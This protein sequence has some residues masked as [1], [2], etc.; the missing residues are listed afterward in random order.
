MIQRNIFK[1]SKLINPLRDT[2][3]YHLKAARA[4]A[5]RDSDTRSWECNR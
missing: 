5:V 2:A 3:V 1:D 4:A